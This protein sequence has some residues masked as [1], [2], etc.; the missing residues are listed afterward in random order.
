M[1]Q[2]ILN[3]KKTYRKDFRDVLTDLAKLKPLKM[4]DIKDRNY[5]VF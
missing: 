1:F 3:T 2:I 5:F 4:S